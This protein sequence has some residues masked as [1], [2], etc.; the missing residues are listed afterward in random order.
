MSIL[1]NILLYIL[2]HPRQSRQLSQYSVGYRLDDWDSISCRSSVFLFATAF[3]LNLM[4]T[5]LPFQWV[6]GALSPELKHPGP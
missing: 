1:F 4:P 3:R 5:Q 2:F 6:S